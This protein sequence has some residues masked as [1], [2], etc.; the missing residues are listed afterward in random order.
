MCVV[1]LRSVLYAFLTVLVVMGLNNVT[2]CYNLYVVHPNR[3]PQKSNQN[4]REVVSKPVLATPI[5]TK[6]KVYK[7]S[8]PC[9]AKGIFSQNKVDKLFFYLKTKFFETADDLRKSQAIPLGL[10]PLVWDH[11]CSEVVVYLGFVVPSCN[12]D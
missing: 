10:Q 9:P 1:R 2:A 3:R 7:Y 6:I 12:F 5:Y 4:G 11:S 8:Q